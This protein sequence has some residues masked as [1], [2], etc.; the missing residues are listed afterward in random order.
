MKSPLLVRIA[1][2][3]ATPSAPPSWRAVM[4]RAITEPSRSGAM[5]RTAA[6]ARLGNSRPIPTPATNPVGSQ[7]FMNS[8]VVVTCEPM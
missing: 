4:F 7:R 2:S 5:S 1:T 3:P 6:L 8:G